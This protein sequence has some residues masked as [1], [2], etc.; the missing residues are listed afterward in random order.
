MN[1]EPYFPILI[2]LGLFFVFRWIFSF[3]LMPG[4]KYLLNGPLRQLSVNYF[5]D[6]AKEKLNIEGRISRWAVEG[7]IGPW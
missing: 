4:L 3:T 6:F 5:K 7:L 1:Y 2:F